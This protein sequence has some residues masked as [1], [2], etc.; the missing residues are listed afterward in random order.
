MWDRHTKKGCIY[1]MN[2][3]TFPPKGNLPQFSSYLAS[4]Q[5]ISSL[6]QG[7][8]HKTFFFNFENFNG[9]DS[10]GNSTSWTR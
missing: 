7:T 3:T 2:E 1:V 8:E 5:L 9:T 10:Y 6:K 4:H